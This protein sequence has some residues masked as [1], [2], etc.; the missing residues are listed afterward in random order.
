MLRKGDNEPMIAVVQRVLNAKVHV[1][2]PHYQASIESGL[3][4]FLGIHTSDT[5]SQA[6]WMANKLAN[7]RIFNDDNDKMN[8]S[9]LETGGGILL[10]SQFTLVGDCMKGHR[11]SFIRAAPPASAAPLVTEVGD[12]L[13]N[14]HGISVKRGVFGAMMQVE[15]VKDRKSVV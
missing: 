12:I 4:V 10:I 3:C 8:C 14:Q 11:P 13:T 9:L 15:L 2:L 6:I 5:Q 7:L 1:K